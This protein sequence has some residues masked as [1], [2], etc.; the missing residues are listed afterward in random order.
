MLAERLKIARVK[1]N[2][3]QRQAAEALN[4][5]TRS[6]QR[7]E[8]IN[9]QCE[10]P[11]ATLVSMANIFDVSIDWLLGRDEFL[12]KRRECQDDIK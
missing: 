6:Y 1:Q 2:M 12:A 8:A 4:L 10:P 7:Y 11:L 5:S 3:T 9:G